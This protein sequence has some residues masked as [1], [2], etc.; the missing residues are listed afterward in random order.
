[1]NTLVLSLLYLLAF[2]SEDQYPNI[3]YTLLIAG[4]KFFALLRLC[5]KNLLLT[6]A[7]RLNRLEM[8]YCNLDL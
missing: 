2:Y 1:M 8:I 3:Q 4:M 7:N 5:I 6:S